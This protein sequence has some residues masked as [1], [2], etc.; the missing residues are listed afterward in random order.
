[1]S[2][3]QQLAN[4]RLFLEVYHIGKL[5]TVQHMSDSTLD[6]QAMPVGNAPDMQQY[7]HSANNI[8]DCH[9]LPEKQRWL[10]HRGGQQTTCDS[11]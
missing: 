4:E 3:R 1:M 6:I 11:A 5:Q 7:T 10:K 8:L 2:N 9:H